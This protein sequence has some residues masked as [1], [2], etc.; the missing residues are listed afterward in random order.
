MKYSKG[1]VR[2]FYWQTH[3]FYL[4]FSFWTLF[5]AFLASTSRSDVHVESVF[6]QQVSR[7]AGPRSF[8]CLRCLNCVCAVTE[9]CSW[10]SRAAS[11][12]SVC[13]WRPQSR[14]LGQTLGE[15]SAPSPLR[16]LSAFCRVTIFTLIFLMEEVRL[17]FTIEFSFTV[18]KTLDASE[19]KVWRRKHENKRRWR[20]KEVRATLRVFNVAEKVQAVV[21]SNSS[22]DYTACQREILSLLLHCIHVTAVVTLQ[23]KCCLHINELRVV[24]SVNV[25]QLFQRS[26]GETMICSLV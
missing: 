18:R 2:G 26:G 23:I 14:G 15:R 19:Q 7:S 10:K 20:H 4:H 8:V 1:S 11:L 24:F 22:T 6:D 25:E 5:W 13:W 16:Q 12:Q 9:S 3:V 21:E 17:C